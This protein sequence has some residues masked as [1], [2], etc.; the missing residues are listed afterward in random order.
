MHHACGEVQPLAIGCLAHVSHSSDWE[1]HASLFIEHMATGSLLVCVGRTLGVPA[2]PESSANWRISD[3][4]SRASMNTTSAPASAKACIHTKACQQ[5]W[6]GIA[7]C[8]NLRY[9]STAY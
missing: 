5:G 1:G 7:P 4:D 8:R 9:C 2:A 6:L 3:S